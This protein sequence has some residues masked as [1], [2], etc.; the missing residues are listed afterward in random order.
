MWGVTPES[1]LERAGW[2]VIEAVKSNQIFPID[3][4]L[5]SRPGPRLVDGLEALAK[6]LHPGVFE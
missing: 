6:I 3:D 5:I 2:E 1:V 4:N